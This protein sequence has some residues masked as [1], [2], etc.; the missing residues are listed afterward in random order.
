MSLFVYITDACREDARTHGLSDEIDKLY[1]RIEAN[2]NTAQ[3]DRF[4]KPYIVKKKLSG[5]QGRLIAEEQIVG[6]HLVVVF[7][8][9]MI[10]GS[11]EYADGFG[12]D[13]VAYGAQKLQGL[14]DPQKLE[15]YVRERSE[16]SPVQPKPD[17][18]EARS[19]RANPAGIPPAAPAPGKSRFN[20]NIL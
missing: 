5:R 1:A 3:F 4:P 17:P 12:L 18:T 7:L 2:Q 15:E 11:R 13:P 8:A 10:R 14:Y 9:V 20:L 6:A 19:V 16:L